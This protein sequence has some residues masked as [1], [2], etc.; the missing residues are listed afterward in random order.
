MTDPTHLGSPPPLGLLHLLY[1]TQTTQLAYVMAKLGLADL[2]KAGPKRSAELARATQTDPDILQ[3]V[4]R[5][6]ASLGLCTE[7]DEGQFALT[8]LGAYLRTDLP[9]SLHARALFNGEVNSPLWGDLL[10]T[11]Q[12][13]APAAERVFGMPIYDYLAG[14]P[15]VGAL[16]DQTMASNARYRLGPVARAYDFSRF[17]TI[18]DVGGGN[19]TLLVFILHAYPEPRGVVFDFPAVA[20]RARAN[21]EAAGLT[22][23][24]TAVGGDALE[25]VPEGGDAYL[26]SGV[27]SGMD[28]ATMITIL[29]NCRAAMG[30]GARLLLIEW[31]MPAGGVASGAAMDDYTVWDTASIDLTM[32]VTFSTGHVRTEAEF[33]ALL[34]VA[35]LRCT[36]IVPTPSSVSVIEAV[37]T[38]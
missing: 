35:G 23:R 15:P 30:K 1:G 3:R 36:A 37:P 8:A 18:V 11:V 21:L 33:R 17:R 13:G 20:E 16:F 26:L 22:G 12:T 4:L 2:L 28:D 27:V 32:L 24:C 38:S 9:G 19:G 14:H 34:E 5:G 25:R 29:Q 10:R 7:V 6:L 31:V